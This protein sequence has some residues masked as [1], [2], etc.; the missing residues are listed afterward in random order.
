MRRRDSE[1]LAMARRGFLATSRNNKATVIP[2]CF[3]HHGDIVYTPIDRKP[4]RKHLA[5]LSNI[6][7]NP[8]VAFLV[9]NYSEDWRLLSYLLMHGNA[10]MVSNTREARRAR[11]LL[12]HKYPQYRWLKLGEAPIL[13]IQVQRSKFWQFQS[14]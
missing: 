11:E 2:V 6:T 1:Y 3:A 13:G 10:S 9:D 14:D 12:L 7:S 8:H 4:K 5:R